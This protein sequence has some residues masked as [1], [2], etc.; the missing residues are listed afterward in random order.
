MSVQPATG[1]R[2]V[3]VINRACFNWG[4]E[5]VK[6]CRYNS[7]PIHAVSRDRRSSLMNPTLEPTLA[8]L[9]AKIADGVVRD[10]GNPVEELATLAEGKII[11]D[12]SHFGVL[13]FAGADATEF[14]QNQLSCDLKSLAGT[15][16]YG[17]YCT[18]KGRMLA[19]FVAWKNGE[20][21]RMIL[22][23]DVLPAI[24]KR[25][26][27]FVLRSKVSVADLSE[28]V[29]LLGAAGPQAAEVLRGAFGVQPT[30][31][32]GVVPLAD[33]GAILSLPGDRWLV[34]I[35]AEA[36]AAA[37]PLLAQGLRPV[38]ASAWDWTDIC[39]GIAFV[40]L[41]T[42]EQFV[43]Q[44]AN[45]E[46]IGGVSF[47]KGCYPGQEIVARTQHLG[48]VK[49]RLYL[50]NVAAEA[51]PGEELF[52]EDVEGQSNGMVASAAPSPMGGT[53]VLAVVQ[54]ASAEASR[55]HLRSLDGPLLA[56]RPLPYAIP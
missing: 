11:A 5:R 41:P 37:W 35:P 4:G 14:L 19:S 26:R 27:M 52:G 31:P 6:C 32:Q 23:R 3:P 48:K 28:P 24:H 8:R 15:S 12:L 36:A 20:A 45:M 22:R 13:E 2:K 46:L 53:D 43:P 7:A 42:Q 33:G 25:L 56:F 40:G 49:R 17:S 55:V 44:M 9:G 16:T 29:A 51:F 50:A 39:N 38:G 47:K 18:P 21:W 34:G 10:F 30:V 1:A 54:R